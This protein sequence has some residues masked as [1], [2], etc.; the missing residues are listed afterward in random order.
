[1]TIRR[2]THSGGSGHQIVPQGREALLAAEIA[3]NA[4]QSAFP[5]TEATSWWMSIKNGVVST[6]NTVQQGISQLRMGARAGFGQ[7]A[8]TGQ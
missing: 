7:P 4:R 6:L 2:H 1:M 3:Q 5:P 8:P